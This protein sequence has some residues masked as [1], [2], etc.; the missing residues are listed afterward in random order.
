MNRHLEHGMLAAYVQGSATHGCDPSG[1][2]DRFELLRFPDRT[3]HGINISVSYVGSE[4]GTEGSAR[5][6]LNCGNIRVALELTPCLACS[7]H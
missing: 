1:L 7:S 4:S 6:T 3:R 2:S 5:L